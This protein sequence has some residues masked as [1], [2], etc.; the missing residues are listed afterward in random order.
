MQTR[1]VKWPALTA[2]AAALAAAAVL[3]GS[4]ADAASP[5]A[6]LHGS[7]SGGGSIQ[8]ESG[9]SERLRCTAYYTSS[10]GGNQLGLAIR[11]ASASNKIEIRGRLDYSGGGSVSGVW[12]ERTF[13]ASGT[14]TGQ[15]SDSRVSLRL[16][17]AIP[18]AMNVTVGKGR[19]SVAISTQGSTLKAVQIGLSR[20]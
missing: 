8:F 18:G 16:S 3:A 5:F 19:Q 6:T 4:A 12:E 15:A 17:G 10:N 9:Q 20:R 11:C 14:A 7:W 1:S 13:N 2:G